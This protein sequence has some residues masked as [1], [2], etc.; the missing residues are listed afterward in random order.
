MKTLPSRLCGRAP[1]FVAAVLLLF[2]AAGELAFSQSGETPKP[3]VA[4]ETTNL[5]PSGSDQTAP[6]SLG[7]R[8][9]AGLK[10]LGGY[11]AKQVGAATG[12]LRSQIGSTTQG[13]PGTVTQA[14]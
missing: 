3:V 11:A 2:L 14:Q 12:Y 9:L 10:R 13:T 4:G 8:M 6:L 5:T 1:M 7:R